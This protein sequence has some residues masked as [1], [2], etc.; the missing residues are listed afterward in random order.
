MNKADDISLHDDMQISV[1]EK[2][3]GNGLLCV[4]HPENWR[5][6]RI[7]WK[8]QGKQQTD[9]RMMS[10]AADLHRCD[11]GLCVKSEPP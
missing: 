7:N 6:C 4:E 2:I 10:R 11:G 3:V 1:F 5:L 8:R 9:G